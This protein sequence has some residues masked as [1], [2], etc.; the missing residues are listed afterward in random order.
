MDWQDEA[1][2]MGTRRQGETSVILEVMT[3]G[4]GRHFGIVRGGRSR[5]LQ[6]VLQS[7]NS[8]IVSWRARLEEQL[9]TFVI[10]PV[11]LRA[12]DMMATEAAL[13]GV[14]HLGHLLR[15]LPEREAFDGLYALAL[16]ICQ[17]LAGEDHAAPLMAVLELA[18]LR[19]LGFGLDLSACAL[20]GSREHLAFVSPRTGR[21]VTA[22]AGLPWAG[23]L[24]RLPD[25]MARSQAL[26]AAGQVS[27]TELA[28]AF[29]LT[30]HFLDQ[31]IYGPRGQEV[32]MARR[33]YV[34][35]VTGEAMQADPPGKA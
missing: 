27:G 7:G 28:D 23:K 22:E 13:Q 16:L 32:P 9:G 30:A 4:H 33:R 34:A 26:G 11:T 8:L 31:N 17:R 14:S 35:L 19:E 3:Q 25:F 2:V 24:L 20:T 21:A 5:K 29:R 1:L 18:L 15:L 12:A 10:E 6:P